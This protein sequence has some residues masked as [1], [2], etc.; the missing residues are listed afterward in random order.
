LV[1]LCDV[2]LND[3]TEQR[4]ALCDLLGSSLVQGRKDLLLFLLGLQL[5]LLNC[6]LLHG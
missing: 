3:L 4:I 5:N 1:I 6:L 2:L